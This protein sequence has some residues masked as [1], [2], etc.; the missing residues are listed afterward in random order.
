MLSLEAGD[1]ATPGT[2]IKLSQTVCQSDA[3]VLLAL[4]SGLPHE[5]HVDSPS[6]LNHCTTIITIREPVLDAYV[7]C[8]ECPE[9][10]SS[11]HPEESQTLTMK[12]NRSCEA[13][14]GLDITLLSAAQQHATLIR[15]VPSCTMGHV[16][17]LTRY[18]FQS[19]S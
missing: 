9:G 11:R 7:N 17:P 15:S 2:H 14:S 12:D 3:L 13:H 16:I 18:K 5:V 19:S 10:I 1:A 4:K 8:Y 6:P